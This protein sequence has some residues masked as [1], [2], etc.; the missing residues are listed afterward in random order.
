M[1]KTEG[2]AASVITEG[3]APERGAQ[4]SRD[5]SACAWCGRVLSSRAARYC[6]RRCRQAAFRLRRR[7]ELRATASLEP[8]RFAYADPPYPGLSSKYYRHEAS[9]AGEVDHAA[10]IASLAAADYTGWRC[11]RRPGP[12]ATCCPS[13]HPGR[14]CARGEANRRAASNLRSALHLG[15]P[16]RRRWP[17][18]TARDPRLVARAASKGVG[19]PSW[20]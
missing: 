15:S 4:T 8:G 14:G 20:S 16:D 12:S 13:V 18:T 11:R 3:H 19:R 9:Y 2:G 10:L 7:R 1:E 6:G 5:T 17:P